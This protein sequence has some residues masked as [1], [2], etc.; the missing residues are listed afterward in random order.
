MN[1]GLS[2]LKDPRWLPSLLCFLSNPVLGGYFRNP[3][4]PGER[5]EQI[6]LM[7]S[8]IHSFNFSSQDSKL[9][10]YAWNVCCMC[11]QASVGMCTG[12][13]ISRRGL[14]TEGSAVMRKGFLLGMCKESF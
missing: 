3:R 7:A 14:D 10:H 13:Q 2:G 12:V 6:Y 9:G 4:Y 8:G 1:L 5:P 11:D